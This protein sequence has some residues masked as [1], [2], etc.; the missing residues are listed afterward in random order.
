[1]PKDKIELSA[2]KIKEI[3]EEKFG[4][5]WDVSSEELRYR[6]G[7]YNTNRSIWNNLSTGTGDDVEFPK[8]AVDEELSYIDEYQDK[9]KEIEADED[10]TDEY[11][12]EKKEELRSEYEWEAI[13]QCEES[14]GYWTVYFQPDYID[15][16]VAIEC[17]LHP[18]YY[19]DEFYLALGGA[20][21]D[22]SPKL[23]AYQ[24]LTTGTLPRDTKIFSD[25]EYFKYVVGEKLY[26]KVLEAA[27]RKEPRFIITKF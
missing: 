27:M 21:M 6:D 11:L 18:F 24:A 1:M 12:E 5:M 10:H 9:L 26:Q 15:E 19:D 23:D 7:F 17:R 2:E 14:L 16:D 8:V 22:L 3:L 25:P 13:Q 4:G 20:G